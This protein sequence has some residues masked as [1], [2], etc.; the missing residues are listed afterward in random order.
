[1]FTFELA[2]VACIVGALLFCI[3]GTVGGAI[4]AGDGS[5]ASSV[6]ISSVL[7]SVTSTPLLSLL[8]A[9]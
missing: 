3:V 1:M 5:M 4:D 9:V 6:P 8:S 2:M 7:S